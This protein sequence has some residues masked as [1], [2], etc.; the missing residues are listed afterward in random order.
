MRGGAGWWATEDGEYVGVSRVLCL[1]K[2]KESISCDF[3][4]SNVSYHERSYISTPVKRTLPVNGNSYLGD[5]RLLS[6]CCGF[7]SLRFAADGLIIGG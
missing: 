5:T 7:G 4:F 3:L 1:P 6:A 2:M